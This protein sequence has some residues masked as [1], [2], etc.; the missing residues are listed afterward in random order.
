MLYINIR[1]YGVSDCGFVEIYKYTKLIHSNL[2]N[3]NKIKI[4]S[5]LK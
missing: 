1:I 5:K 4:V 3:L 2:K